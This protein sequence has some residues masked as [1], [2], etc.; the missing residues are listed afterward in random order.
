MGSSFFHLFH[1]LQYGW[2]LQWGNYHLQN[3]TSSTRVL[4]NTNLYLLYICSYC[5]FDCSNF[6]ILSQRIHKEVNN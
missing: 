2:V 4:Q 3:S 5:L 6:L 1:L